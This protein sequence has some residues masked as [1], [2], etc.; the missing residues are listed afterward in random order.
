MMQS[1]GI[2]ARVILVA[3]IPAITLAV[4][5]TAYYTH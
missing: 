4:F 3:V 5:M 2:R 1:W